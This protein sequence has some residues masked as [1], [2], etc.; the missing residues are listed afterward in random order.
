MNPRTLEVIILP[1]KSAAI[2][3]ADH[4]WK[5]Y[6]GNITPMPISHPVTP[7]SRSTWIRS[8]AVGC[9]AAMVAA[10][11]AAAQDYPNKLIHVYMGFPAGTYLDIVTRHFTDRLQ[12]LAG[13]TVVVENKVGAGS[14]IAM[15]AAARSK[16]DGYTIVFGPGASAAAVQFKSLPFDPV[17]DFVRIGAVV[18]F[19][20]VLVVNPRTTPVNTV[21]ELAAFL[22]KKDKVSYGAPNTLS[23]V[24]GALFSDARG[25]KAEP[26]NY[27]SAADGIRDLN[28]GDIDFIFNDAGFAF[29]QMR[30]G[31]LKGLA[32]TFSKRSANAPD[33]PTMLESGFP[34]FDFHGWM[35]AYAPAGTPP[36]AVAKLEK[37]FLEIAKSEETTAF[38]KRIGAEPFALNAAEFTKWEDAEFAAWRDRAKIADI[39]PN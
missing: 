30:E 16:P 17:K 23:L 27:K 37:W 25:L 34:G 5:L 38:F 28:A 9:I 14:M 11:P 20:F 3:R 8:A 7:S 24:G 21:E 22:K 18:A 15:E 31:K 13:Q 6:K 35:G 32:I 10:L 36:D 19:P 29:A 33:L 39:K 26:I 2:R 1:K 4:G 12:K